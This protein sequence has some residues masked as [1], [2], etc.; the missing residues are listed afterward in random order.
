MI[1]LNNAIPAGQEWLLAAKLSG[2]KCIT[3]Q[4][5]YGYERARDRVLGRYF[6]AIICISEDV[7]KDLVARRVRNARLVS[8]HN[9]IDVEEF[10]AERKK[11]K[12]EILEELKLPP[13]SKLVGIIANIMDWKGHHVVIRA[14]HLLAEKYGDLRCLIVGEV[15]LFGADQSVLGELR[16]LV[17][18]CALEKR[19]IFTGYRDDIPDIMHMLDIVIHASVKPEPFGRVILEGMAARKPVVA[20]NIG[21]PCEIIED[22]KSGFL[23]PPGDAVALAG[24]IERLLVDRDLAR[25]IGEAGWHRVREEFSSRRMVSRVQGLYEKVLSR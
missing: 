9:G 14:I 13:G 20:T 16:R 3:H 19:V 12:E 24:T 7:R 22:E 15:S 1:H 11:D 5:G 8:I 21:G 6:D 17:R 25:K 4:R 23:V 2:C 18:T 10:S